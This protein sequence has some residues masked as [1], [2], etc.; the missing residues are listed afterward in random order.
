M[1]DCCLPSSKVPFV[2]EGHQLTDMAEIHFKLAMDIKELLLKPANNAVYGGLS[3][4][5]DG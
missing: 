3:V 2:L 5:D 1:E 4:S